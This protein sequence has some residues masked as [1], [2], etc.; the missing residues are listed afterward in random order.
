MLRL[1]I[2]DIA[3]SKLRL[4]LT[5]LSIVLGV[6]FVAGTFVLT[7]TINRA[8]DT[9]FADANAS[10]SVVV[11]SEATVSDTVR[12]PLPE[13][14]LARV[15][16]VPGVQDAGG[17]AF[18]LAQLI[19]RD[20]KAVSTGGAPTL[21]GNWGTNPKLNPFVLREG[22]PPTGPDDVVIDAGTAKDEGFGPGDRVKVIP[23]TG[24]PQEFTVSGVAGFGKEDNLAGATALLFSLPTAQRVLGLEGRFTEIR[25]L[26]DPGV[27]DGVL[28]A[29]I[30]AV[31]PRGVE[32]ITGEQSAADQS[33]QIQDQLSIIRTA[34]LVFAIVALFVGGFIIFNSFSIT[35]AQRTRSL[36]LLRA[37][38][39]SPGQVTRLVLIESLVLGIGASILGILAGIA[40]AVGLRQLFSAFGG[41]LP[42]TTLQVQARTIIVSLV[43]GIGITLIAALRP[44]RRASTVP[45]VAALRT[46]IQPAEAPVL[47]RRILAVL[48]TAAGLALLLVGLLADVPNRL[49]FIGGGALV[50]FVGASML[51]T[52]VARPLARV[53]GFPFARMSV[54]GKLGRENAMRNPHRTAQTAAALMIGLALVS[55]ASIFASSLS[56]SVKDTVEQRFPVALVGYSEQFVPFSTDVADQLAKQPGIALVSQWRMGQFKEGRSTRDL[57]AADPAQIPQVYE[58]GVKSGS[59]AALNERGTIMVSDSLASDQ[60]LRVGS[61]IPALF[62]RTGQQRLRV[63]GVYDDTTFGDVLTS[64]DTYAANFSP[65]YQDMIIFAKAAPGATEAQITAAQTT[66]GD[67]FPGLKIQTKDE[68]ISDVQQQVNQLLSLIYILLGFAIIIAI[69][70]IVNTLALSVFERTREIGLL[71][72]VGF[73]RGQVRAM[74]RYEAVIVSLLG[75]LFGLVVGVLLG[76]L[77]IRSVPDDIQVLSVPVGSLIVFLVLAGIAGVLAALGPARRASRLDIL[78]AIAAE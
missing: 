31:M 32:A 69:F 55:L 76:V 8:F 66:V 18:G 53:L 25:V 22:S 60:G 6:A 78:K 37:V 1:A 30:Q 41:E 21:A 3:S 74:V 4:I 62:A 42:S 34:L 40:V 45:P 9:V 11:Q 70:G 13:S 2:R 48:G 14:V 12:E 36:A 20:G 75:G 28:A 35:V 51:A 10:T 71:R 52:E 65:P 38:G 17:S 59:I 24:T 47:R 23:P 33:K 27:S 54:A 26:A 56:A 73:G 19:G 29:R 50:L 16:A 46:D 43:L 5:S 39:A 67:Q 61:T 57:Y 63:V 15:E 7:D 68:Y 58:M 49:Y 77:I 44:A 64:L 72:A